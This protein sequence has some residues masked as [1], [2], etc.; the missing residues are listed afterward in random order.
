M[1]LAVLLVAC[2]AVAIVQIGLDNSK[3]RRQSAPLSRNEPS[4]ARLRAE[5]THNHTLI[6]QFKPSSDAGAM[7][8][9]AD[10]VAARAEVA[11]LEAKAAGLRADAS[12]IPF[13]DANR[14]PTKAMTRPEFLGGPTSARPTTSS[15]ASALIAKARPVPPATACATPSSFTGRLTPPAPPPCSASA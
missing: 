5:N 14:D 3:L 1:R 2:L 13:I 8:I 15:A 6:A 11:L 10:K 12:A 4:L 7:A 9:H